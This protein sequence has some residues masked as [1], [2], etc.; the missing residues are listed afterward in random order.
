M[1]L[2]ERLA[3]AKD[4]VHPATWQVLRFFKFEH[5][6][7]H[8]RIVSAQFADLALTLVEDDELSGPELTVA[9]RKLMEAKDCA[10][11]AALPPD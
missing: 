4:T 2:A 5:L 11:R 9:L 8:M 6:Q 10:V 1:S 7:G 3:A